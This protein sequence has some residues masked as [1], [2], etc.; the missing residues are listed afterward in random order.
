MSKQGFFNDGENEFN[1][2]RR[3]NSTKSAS[4]VL[5]KI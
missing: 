3:I 1:A 4:A 2:A 5:F